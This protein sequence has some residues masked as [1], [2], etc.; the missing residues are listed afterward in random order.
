MC[1]GERRL[2]Q[3]IEY[4]IEMGKDPVDKKCAHTFM[5]WVVEDLM[6]EEGWRLGQKDE[7]GLTPVEQGAQPGMIKRIAG[8][9][10][11]KWFMERRE[12]IG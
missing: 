5:Q 6:K 10:A 3:G 1:A 4:L 2:E 9:R 11:I 8:E 7:S 12:K